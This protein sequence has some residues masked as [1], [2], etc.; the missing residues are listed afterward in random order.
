MQK[1]K[2]ITNFNKKLNGKTLNYSTYDNEVYTLMRT[3]K[4]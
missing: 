2:L 1:K 3:L 4:T